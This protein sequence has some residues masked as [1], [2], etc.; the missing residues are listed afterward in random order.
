MKL[1]PLAIALLAILLLG[2][3]ANAVTVLGPYAVQLP[4]DVQYEPPSSGLAYGPVMKYLSST[5][6]ARLRLYTETGK[7]ESDPIAVM[8]S[9][10]SAFGE[11]YGYMSVGGAARLSIHQRFDCWLDADEAL[12]VSDFGDD[13]FAL[14]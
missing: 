10:N 6:Y 1:Y 5:G 12:A 4:V 14:R 11:L 3:A 8:K 2:V 9:D 13:T 7:W